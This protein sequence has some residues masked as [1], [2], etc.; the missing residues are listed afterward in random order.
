M[1]AITFRIGNDLDLDELIELY[2]AT[3][4]GVRRPLDDRATMADMLRHASLIVTAW[5]GPLLVGV[6]RSL[7]DFSYV[8]Y[9]SDLAVRESHQHRGIGRDLIHHTREALGPRCKLVLLSAPAAVDYYPRL[10]FTQHPSAWTLDA[11][12]PLRE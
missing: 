1:S 5:E 8:A 3:S 9:L 10:G 7:T 11:H 6:S 2:S 4:L 12:E